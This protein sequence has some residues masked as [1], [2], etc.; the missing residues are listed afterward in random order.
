[1]CQTIEANF[2]V[3][4]SKVMETT[5]IASPYFQV[6]ES[7]IEDDSITKFEYIFTAMPVICMDKDG[8]HKIE[9][10]DLDEHGTYG[11]L[12]SCKCKSQ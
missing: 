12:Q 4:Y 3:I 6:F 5:K 2:Y 1:M 8:E 11:T 7:S 10:R 9:S